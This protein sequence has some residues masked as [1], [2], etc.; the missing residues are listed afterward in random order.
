MTN[1]GGTGTLHHESA[2]MQSAV[3]QIDSISTHI[4]GT[5]RSINTTVGDASAWQGDA[6]GAMQAAMAHWHEAATKMD[7]VLQD[8]QTGVHGS[9]VTVTAQE[10]ESVSAFTRASSSLSFG[11]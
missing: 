1:P 11:I 9:D 5:L 8:I 3:H 4:R 6:A 7:R 2:E 10:A